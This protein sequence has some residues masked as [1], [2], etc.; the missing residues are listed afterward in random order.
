MTVCAAVNHTLA[1]DL[2]SSLHVLSPLHVD[3]VLL[4]TTIQKKLGLTIEDLVQI[5]L[6][7]LLKFDWRTTTLLHLHLVYGY[8][9]L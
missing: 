2:A 6:F 3:L 9:P 1:Q 8:F 4:G 5:Y 7:V